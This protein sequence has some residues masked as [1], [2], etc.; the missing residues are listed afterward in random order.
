MM[1]ADKD[2]DLMMSPETLRDEN[3]E[4]YR[5]LM[6]TGFPMIVQQVIGMSLN[7][8]D[9][10][11]VGKVSEEALAAVGAANQVYFIFGIILFGLYSGA[12]VIAVQYW[13]IGDL[14]MLRRIV[15]IDYT[16]CMVLAVPGTI[17]AFLAAPFLI[18]IFS[19]DGLVLELGV[20][21]L[22]IAC[23]SYV[24]S[25][26][27]FVI[28]YNSRVIRDVKRPTVINA[29][30]ILLNII[31]NYLLIYGKCGFP[32]M[33]VQGAAIATLTARIAECVAM[34][35][36]VYLRKEYPLK[37]GISELFDYSPQ[38]FVRVMKT[39]IPVVLGE[40]IW[41]LS[42]STIFA[43][44]GR[45]SAAALAVSQ[46]AVTVTDFFQT[47]YFGIGN[48]SAVFV[49]EE[50]G[51][52]KKEKAFRYSKN[53]I[54][55]TWGLNIVMTTVLIFLRAPIAAIY[56]FEPETTTMLMEAL[57]VYALLLTPKMFN[58]MI[59]CG[60]LRTGG[61]TVYTTVVDS[62]INVFM[63]IPL[64]FI[65]VLVLK[66]PLSW[67]MALSAIADLLKVFLLFRR[68]Y[69]KSWMTV[70]TGREEKD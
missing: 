9:T 2:A 38:L 42:V 27:T 6:I 50:I 70:F 65:G 21:Y 55:V 61:D 51:K 58:Y 33:G 10:I 44:Y 60:I 48:A 20:S 68:Y 69:S 63:Q 59:I 17:F 31:L 11:M 7:L 16:M 62:A 30:A 5:K 23:F 46:I 39:A 41:A 12:S 25:G 26:L 35:M 54:K 4:F 14:K 64:A 18:T 29:C 43:A 45:I 47:I 8:A 37:A 15:G 32:Q 53:I 13:G 57:F 3:R 56:D 40:G 36:S 34:M 67:V 66:W 49:G 52:G 22:R 24:F 28:S 1:K 19:D